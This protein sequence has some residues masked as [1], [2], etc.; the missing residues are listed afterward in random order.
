MTENDWPD[1]EGET[2]A[3][4][5]TLD[6]SAT[7]LGPRST[8]PMRLRTLVDVML[9]NPVA[10]TL[11]WGPDGVMIYNDA[12]AAI[13]GARHPG[14]LGMPVCAAWPEAADFN[15]AV[16]EAGHAGRHQTFREVH[17]VLERAGTPADGWFDLFY[18]PVFGDGGKVEGILAAT[19]EI[20]QHVKAMRARDA[21][22]EELRRVNSALDE[23]RA[24]LEAANR[25]LAGDMAFLNQLFKRSPSF[26]AV[27]LGPE[28]RFELTNDS[29]DRLIQH[30]AVHGRTVRDALPEVAEQ[31]FC[32]LLDSVYRNGEA[33]RGQKVEVM[34]D[35][36]EGQALE[37]RFLDFV[38][39]PLKDDGGRTYGIFVEGNDVTEHTL[40]GER[41]RVAQEAGGIGTFEWNPDVGA[42]VVSDSYR[43]VFGIA[44]D[45]PVD[46]ALLMSLVEPGYHQQ[47]G[48]ERLGRMAN[49]LEY[50]EYPIRRHDTGELRW[51]A[52]KGQLVGGGLQQ[53][54]RYLG[55]AYDITVRKQAEQALRELNDS[56]ERRVS[57]E[58]AERIK[59]ENALRQ[60]QKMEAVGQLASG[61]AHDF[62]NVLQIISSNLQLM[63]RDPRP[64]QL[65]ARL[66]T[67]LSAVERGS[68]LSYQLLAFAR[69]QPLLSVVT[70]LNALLAN[71]EPLL[72]RALGD[73]VHLA[74]AV[75][76]DLW[77]TTVD[78]NQMENALLNLA[79]N[80]RDAMHGSGSLAIDARNVPRGEGHVAITV[81]DTGCGMP[82]EVL[83]K[84]FEPF[85]T[86]KEPGKGTGLGMSMV[87][88]FV[89]QSGGEIAID[90]TPGSGTSIT[91]ELP[92]AH[93]AAADDMLAAVETLAE[94]A[95]GT[96]TILVVED[97]PA[98]RNAVVEMLRGLGYHVLTAGDGAAA[99]AV[100]R[101]GAA[102]DLVFSDVSMPG[103]VDCASL[104]RQVRQLAPQTAVLL[105][106]G[107]AIER[108]L[109]DGAITND[110]ELLPKP[111]RLPQLAQAIRHELARMRE[112]H[113][114]QTP[115]DALSFLVVDDDRDTR[116][117]VCELLEALG[118][119]A[120]GADGAEAAL[121]LLKLS[122]F[123]VLFTDLNMP[124]MSGEALAERAGAIAPGLRV[125]LSSGEGHVPIDPSIILLP[126]PYDLT[127]LQAI[128]AALSQQP[129]HAG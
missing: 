13:C 126:K 11:L 38:Y 107:H 15:R 56:L 59:A 10:E 40:A 123:D 113:A 119:R 74:I 39:Q 5:R 35:C 87:Y 61:V 37:S 50:A 7:P 92:R 64:A 21:Y 45:V 79:I 100:L 84:V 17:F 44:P 91:I 54:A 109:L 71:I 47:S 86:T 115:A 78:P 85:Y 29:Y 43:E 48:V 88:G 57:S 31:G 102:V 18:A 63:E 2:A 66:G 75:E 12:Y 6:W 118:M 108:S 69:R 110:V 26:I 70:D 128:I 3:R 106:S 60:A 129:E 28:H 114:A 83:A 76:P 121:R 62:N 105:T 116:E 95:R 46:D 97:D 81:S 73:S 77:H 93:G 96:E 80:A 72:Q 4:V 41:L 65:A 19:I 98:V 20:T 82:A 36:G 9:R 55:V 16:L 14:L 122:R 104:V 90:S 94:L 103:D 49:P 30:R 68:K 52:R 34:L 33:F 25:Q 22:E 120:Q 125:I 51:I 23:Q 24:R 89:K 99:L 117:L 112:P 111:Y 53:G 67:A 124:G 8:W 1:C 32:E 101:A 42:L 127:Q 58:V 27:L